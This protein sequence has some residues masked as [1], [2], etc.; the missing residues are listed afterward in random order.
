[1]KMKIDYKKHWQNA[2]G[3]CY[4]QTITVNAIELNK[5]ARYFK[6]IK[7][8]I[9]NNKDKYSMET[10]ICFKTLGETPNEKY[11]KHSIYYLNLTQRRYLAQLLQNKRVLVRNTILKFKVKG[12]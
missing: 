10:R 6:E 2:T 12:E 9:E 8:D 1:M 4:T 11:E 5:I 7:N 3:T